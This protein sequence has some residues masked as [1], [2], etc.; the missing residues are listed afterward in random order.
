MT[1]RI[2]MCQR[3]TEIGGE[4]DRRRESERR[5]Q[6]MTEQGEK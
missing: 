5:E 2:D 6:K 4:R 3:E 1:N